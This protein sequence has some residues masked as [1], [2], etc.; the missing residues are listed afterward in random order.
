MTKN[1]INYFE[2]E[3]R[4]RLNKAVPHACRVYYQDSEGPEAVYKF[5]E[6]LNRYGFV[7]VENQRSI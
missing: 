4:E 6:A 5:L 7:I 2:P 1:V 3:S